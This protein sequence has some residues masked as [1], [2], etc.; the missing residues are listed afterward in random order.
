MIILKK[1]LYFWI[2]E[3]FENAKETQTV[4]LSVYMSEYKGIKKML[5]SSNNNEVRFALAQ[6]D[7]FFGS[8]EKEQIK[9]L[10]G[11]SRTPKRKFLKG[12]QYT[13]GTEYWDGT[14][15]GDIN[16]EL[17]KLYVVML[18]KGEKC[19]NDHLLKFLVQAQI[20]QKNGSMQK[21]KHLDLKKNDWWFSEQVFTYNSWYV[22]LELTGYMDASTK[23]AI[24]K[25]NNNSDK[26]TARFLIDAFFN[27]TTP[28]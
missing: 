6:V 21:G 9:S 26:I 11:R 23:N 28:I 24:R 22:P 1:T 7:S 18:E 12:W 8:N 27:G 2:Y 5:N 20:N 16:K 4:E 10:K 17:L 19:S 3:Q 13:G 15:M 25:I 14:G